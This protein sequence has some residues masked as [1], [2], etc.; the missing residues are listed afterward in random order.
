[1]DWVFQLWTMMYRCV[2]HVGRDLQE[3]NARDAHPDNELET[4]EGEAAATQ[5]FA[6]TNPMTP[7]TYTPVA[8]DDADEKVGD[9]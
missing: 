7:S 4:A 1:M 3:W 6:G 2:L 9:A 8:T 5:A